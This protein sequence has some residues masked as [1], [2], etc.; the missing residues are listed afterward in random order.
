MTDTSTPVLGAADLDDH[1]PQ[2]RAPTAATVVA[3]VAPVERTA[4]AQGC[5]RQPVNST[6]PTLR[7][8]VDVGLVEF[9][10]LKFMALGRTRRVVSTR[11]R[12]WEASVGVAG[13]PSRPCD[14]RTSVRWSSMPS[15][16]AQR[17]DPVRSPRSRVTSR[18]INSRGG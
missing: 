5:S 6:P 13:E 10:A 7:G 9:T 3:A 4:L 17:R 8:P 14:R 2:R 12:G 16:R 18:V 1:P 15:S 11:C